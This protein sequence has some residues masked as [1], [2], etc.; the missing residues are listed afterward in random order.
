[1]NAQNL[2]EAFGRLPEED[3]AE[4]LTPPAAHTDAQRGILHW[5]A[6]AAAIAA[7]AAIVGGLAFAVK[8]FSDKQ[9]ILTSQ[10]DPA[11]SAVPAESSVPAEKDSREEEIPFRMRQGIGTYDVRMT[12]LHSQVILSYEQYQALP[13]RQDLSLV[14]ISSPEAL[15]GYFDTGAMILIYE[16]IPTSAQVPAAVSAVSVVRG[17]NRIVVDAVQLAPDGEPGKWCC[18]LMID[19]SDLAKANPDPAASSLPDAEITVRMAPYAPGTA[20]EGE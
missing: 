20:P 19:K 2:M 11:A 14:D 18:F 9:K 17:E 5:V 6:G 13:V 15:R 10:P 8:V 16:D 3:I 4:S 1:M 12:A 7:T